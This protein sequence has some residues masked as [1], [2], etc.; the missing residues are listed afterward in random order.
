MVNKDKEDVL[1]QIQHAPAWKER[2]STDL[3]VIHGSL[4]KPNDDDG[5][6]YMRSVHMR[7]G[8]VDVGYHYVIRRNGII[9]LGRP[10]HAI[11]NHSKNRNRD[12]IGICMIGGGDSKHRP[13]S[14][15]Y[16][17]SQMDSL[18][19]LCCTLIR[20]FPEADICGHNRIDANSLCPVFNVA[21]WWAAISYELRGLNQLG[22]ASTYPLDSITKKNV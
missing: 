15:D 11:G 7:Q 5:V 10:I 22:R 20:V 1:L 19:H 13:K 9:E 6:D 14:P 4:T 17:I 21:D 12:S 16:T 3:I 2:S 8:C 18:A